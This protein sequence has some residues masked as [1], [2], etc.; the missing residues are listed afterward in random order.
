MNDLETPF[1]L[2]VRVTAW[3]EFTVDTLASKT[4]VP[5]PAGTTIE[6]GTLAA[7]LLLDRRTAWP[8]VG[9]VA[10]NA[11]VQEDVAGPVREL[12]AHA[13]VLTTEIPAP[14]RVTTFV[15]LP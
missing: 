2:A 8:P 6:A 7:G 1:A 10:F 13:I 11:T 15:G 9:A 14:L 3:L 5:A 12:L 4:A